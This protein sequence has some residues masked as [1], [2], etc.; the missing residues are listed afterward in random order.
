MYVMGNVVI[1]IKRVSGGRQGGDSVPLAD[2]YCI[3]NSKK[4]GG[5]RRYFLGC[6]MATTGAKRSLSPDPGGNLR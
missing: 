6:L 5:V 3:E 2:L 4:V 1:K